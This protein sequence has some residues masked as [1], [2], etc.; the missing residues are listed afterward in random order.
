[1]PLPTLPGAS[2]LHPIL[3]YILFHW[4]HLSSSPHTQP[5]FQKIFLGYLNLTKF[6]QYFGKYTDTSVLTTHRRKRGLKNVTQYTKRSNLTLETF[7][8][9][10]ALSALTSFTSCSLL[11]SKI[12]PNPQA[13]WSCCLLSCPV[14]KAGRIIQVAAKKGALLQSMGP[15]ALPSGV[16]VH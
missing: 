15:E 5:L 16:L 10:F 13:P 11:M 12:Y 3:S 8:I 6:S 1:M 9:I 14:N 2:Q 4:P 7:N